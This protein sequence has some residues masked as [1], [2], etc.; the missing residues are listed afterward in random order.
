MVINSLFI[1]PEVTV[2]DTFLYGSFCDVERRHLNREKREIDIQ[3][4]PC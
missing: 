4:E 3:T 1:R 2:L